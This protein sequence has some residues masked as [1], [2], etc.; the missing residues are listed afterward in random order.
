MLVLSINLEVIPRVAKSSLGDE[1][2]LLAIVKDEKDAEAEAD[3][4][5]FSYAKA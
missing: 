4:R 2:A 1:S 5:F 3:R